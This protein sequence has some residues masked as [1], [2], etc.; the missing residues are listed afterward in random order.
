MNCTG[1]ERELRRAVER[2]DRSV[3]TDLREHAAEC[4]RCAALWEQHDVLEHAVAA[5][6]RHVPAADL[7]DRVMAHW[8]FD[9][10]AERSARLVAV[11]RSQPSQSD[12]NGCP[13][14]AAPARTAA[15]TRT[16]E[17]KPGS[18]IMVAVALAVLAALLS[19]LWWQPDQP[20]GVGAP[21]VAQDQPSLEATRPEPGRAEVAD[22]V[23]VN[24]PPPGPR[25]PAVRLD[26]A[27]RDAGSAWLELASQAGGTVREMSAFL[28]ERALASAL[29][30][31]TE[32]AASREPA[33]W[34]ETLQRELEPISRDV[35]KAMDFLREAVPAGNGR[36]L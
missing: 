2:R 25:E 33:R 24:Q 34:T 18:R 3:P 21:R 7:A 14:A 26:A 31:D 15:S 9:A 12:G 35:G 11:D 32:P 19:P 1:F 5:W 20:P 22:A 16:V 23:V 30:P 28:P 8:A 6:K 36:A 27:V 17:R 4:P 10:G 29:R 13:I